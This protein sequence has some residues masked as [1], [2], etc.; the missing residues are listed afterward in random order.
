MNHCPDC[1]DFLEEGETEFRNINLDTRT[2]YHCANC[3]VVWNYIKDA[4]KETSIIQ[5]GET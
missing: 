3:Q 2:M 1:G 4:Y 5:R